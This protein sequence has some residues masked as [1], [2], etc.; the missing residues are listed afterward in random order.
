MNVSA[1]NST[2]TRYPITNNLSYLYQVYCSYIILFRNTEKKHNFLSLELLRKS[3][4]VLVRKYY[5]PVAGW[6]DINGDEID[7]I[8]STE[9]FN[10]PPFSSQTLS[11]DY[12]TLAQHVHD[13]NTELLVPKYPSGIITKENTDIP[14]FLVKATYVDDGSAVVLGVT[15]HHSLMDGSAFWMFM[16]NW[17][18]VSRQL[19]IQGDQ[20]EFNLPFPPTFGFPS[21]DHLHDASQSFDHIE[22]AIVDAKDCAREFQPGTERIVE[23]VLTVSVEQQLKIRSM[24][25][26]HSVNFTEMLCAIFWK[27]ISEVRLRARP[28][29]GEARSLFTC[30][31]NPRGRLGISSTLCA[32]PVINMA[33]WETVGAVSAYD[34]GCVAQ[35]VSQS[36]NKCTG[37]YLASSFKFILS[38]R[39][40]ELEDEQNG[41]VDKKSMLVYVCPMEA[42]CTVSSSRSF[43]IYETD[44]GF[45]RPEY[46]RPPFLPFDGC[47]RIWPTPQ[48]SCKPGAEGAPLEIYLSQPESLDL[49]SSS[50]LRQFMN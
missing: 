44:F 17:A 49:A 25:R 6:F 19:S 11:M 40:R 16:N 21:I 39:K 45:G 41:C 38:Q 34:V 1:P 9:K 22:Y 31:V 13:S 35:L 36:L 26:N 7:V 24:A 48:Y 42:K 30:A 47:L 29:I 43:P 15:Y 37:T 32:S 27:G 46:V 8:F 14:M 23:T 28:E 3:L 5:Q 18:S 20:A 12:G 10:D 2:E 4:H 50:L 33:A